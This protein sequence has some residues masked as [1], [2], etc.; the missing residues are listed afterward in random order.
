MN[1]TL[2]P[3]NGSRRQPRL[4]FGLLAVT[5]PILAFY[6]ILLR[7]TV[8]L[9]EMDDYDA[10][11][12]FLNGYVALHGFR[13]RLLFFVSSQH[14]HYKLY[15][16]H[17]VFLAELRLTGHINFILL[18]QFGNLFVL[19]TAGVLWLLFKPPARRFADRL[20]LFAPVI[21]LLFAPRYGDTLNW[22][23]GSLQ[24]LTV[25]FFALLALAL[26]DRETTPAFVG[27]CA[28]M[29]CAICSSGNGFFLALVGLPFLWE[30]RQ[31]RR[32]LLWALCALAMAGLYAYHFRVE[33]MQSPTTQSHPGI[34]LVLFPLSFLAGAAGRVKICIL[35]GTLALA[36]AGYLVAKGWR[37]SD[38][39][40]FY[41]V[42]FIIITAA[43]VD[44]TRYQFGL[45]AALALRYCIYSQLL[46]CLLYMATLRLGAYRLLTPTR[47][48]LALRSFALIALIFCLVCDVREVQLLHRRTQL[49]REHYVAWTSN[50]QQVSLVPDEDPNLQNLGM[51][52]FRRRAA[53]TLLRSEELGIYQPPPPGEVSPP[54]H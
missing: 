15:F 9:P 42:M 4:L 51:T 21:L 7:E 33:Q 10:V 35:L 50:P 12:A 43:G 20:L 8:N 29:I 28:S 47:G 27:A 48:R 41:A 16:E 23:M 14:V 26:L 11:L 31:R 1:C 32:M 5:L 25:V 53:L 46:A 40:T 6:T 13:A 52:E 34:I 22:A 49:I 38:P 30:R 37:K 18:Q 19:F 3:S 39:A 2:Q 24:N 54:Q 36:F 17:L 44:L 45:A